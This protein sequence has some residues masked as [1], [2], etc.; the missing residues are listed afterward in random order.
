MQLAPRVDRLYLWDASPNMRRRAR[1]HLA[2]HPNVQILDSLQFGSF[3]GLPP[4][5]RVLV[6][7][8]VQ[9]MTPAEFSAWLACWASWLAPLGQIVVSDVIPPEGGSWVEFVDLLRFG[10]R[11]RFLLR[12][13]RQAMGE[14]GQYR[15]TRKTCP[16]TRLSPDELRRRGKAA[17]LAVTVLPRNLTH[18]PRRITAVF[19]ASAPSEKGIR[20]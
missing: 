13:V 4:L 20:K 7:S 2:G 11:R 14:L 5:D 1:I 17:N 3:P 16:L 6:N 19:T 8:V 15:R 9:Y 12:A 18:F 10:A